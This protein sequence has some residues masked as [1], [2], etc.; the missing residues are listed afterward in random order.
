MDNINLL[1]KYAL[2][3]LSKYDST[4]KNLEL[5]LK[6]KVTRIK[7]IETNKKNHL[8]KFINQLIVNLESK[9][10][11]NDENFASK[12]IISLFQQGKSETF[13]KNTLMKK[14]IDKKII[15]T[16]LRNF[17]KKIPD[18]KIESAKKFAIKKRLGKYGNTKNKEKDLSKMSRAGFNYQIAKDALGYD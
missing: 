1:K 14:G 2:A 5:I 3:Y 7:N 15:I 9:K 8:F 11:I 6:N 16:T 10:I 4:K 13:I 17:E 18:W 12:K